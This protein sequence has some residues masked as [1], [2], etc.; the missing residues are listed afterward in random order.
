MAFVVPAAG[1]GVDAAPAADDVRS[2]VRAHLADYKAPDRVVVLEAMPL[3][4][5]GKIDRR[6]LTARVA[7]SV[8]SPPG[9]A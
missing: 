7:P 1:T 6:A 3:T 8:G 5:I 4:P 9:V 2:W